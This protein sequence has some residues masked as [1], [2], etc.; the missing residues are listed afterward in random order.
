LYATKGWW[1][2][3]AV[4][5]AGADIRV[6]RPA[7]L[8][9]IGGAALWQ[10]AAMSEGFDGER[11]ALERIAAA[12]DSGQ[13]WLDLSGL[14]LTRLPDALFGLTGLRRLNLGRYRTLTAERWGYG[15]YNRDENAWNRVAADLPRLALL[16]SLEQVCLESVGCDS[17]ASLSSFGGLT[18]LDCS[19]NEIRDL[20]PI[21]GL[22]ALQ[23][24]N[25]SQT[26]VSDLG[27]IN[28]LTALAGPSVCRNVM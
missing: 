22:T 15:G 11:I 4:A 28:G 26:Q 13:D 25:C 16:P 14:R 21:N 2:S 10:A 6:P 19:Q 23:S 7:R 12:R 24:L 1:D 18:W 27:P 3:E 5:R 9:L 20:G 8:G 17:L